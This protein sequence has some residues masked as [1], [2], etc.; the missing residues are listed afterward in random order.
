MKFFGAFPPLPACIPCSWPDEA[1]LLLLAYSCSSLVSSPF[2]FLMAVPSTPQAS[3]W[4]FTICPDV[5]ELLTVEALSEPCAGSV[6]FHL[7]Y[8]VV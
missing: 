3:W 2:L 6:C 4:L 7:D 8:N 1:S 5:S